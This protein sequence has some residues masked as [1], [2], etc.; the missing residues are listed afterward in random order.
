ML[1]KLKN[2]LQ[3]KNNH[4]NEKTVCPLYGLGDLRWIEP[5]KI[6]DGNIEKYH[7]KTFPQQNFTMST[8]DESGPAKKQRQLITMP[9]KEYP[10][11]REVPDD[12]KKLYCT[13]CNQDLLA[14]CMKRSQIHVGLKDHQKH[15]HDNES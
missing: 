14:V 3:I 13:I 2:F 15:L 11:F 5:L 1:F 8:G 10:F 9:L 7:N 4:L 12:R 6:S